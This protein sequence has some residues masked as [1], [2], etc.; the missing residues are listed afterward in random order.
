MDG[1]EIRITTLHAWKPVRTGIKHRFQLMQDF[2]TIHSSSVIICYHMLSLSIPISCT[3]FL[4]Q[5]NYSHGFTF[6]SISGDDYN[7]Q[8][9]HLF[10]TGPKNVST[11]QRSRKRSRKRRR[12]AA[13]AS[14][15]STWWRSQSSGQIFWDS[16]DACHGKMV[17]NPTRMGSSYESM[18]S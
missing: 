9:V 7:H 4:H 3:M 10:G 13:P 1:G 8:F 12:R 15:P 16:N 11:A 2:A 5:H 14:G 6:P 17:M 18:G